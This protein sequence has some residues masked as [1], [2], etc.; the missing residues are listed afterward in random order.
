MG[1]RLV[2][3]KV[4]SPHHN[5]PSPVTASTTVEKG[6]AYGEVGWK[7]AVLAG[8]EGRQV[9]YVLDTEDILVKYLWARLRHRDADLWAKIWRSKLEEFHAKM[10]AAS[11]A[12]KYTHSPHPGA[13]D[14][15]RME[16]LSNIV[17]SE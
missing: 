17:G 3:C 4:S 14:Q 9:S 8:S 13:A 10:K 2:P 5:N 1:L 16:L 6:F 15:K 7:L 11:E 12:N